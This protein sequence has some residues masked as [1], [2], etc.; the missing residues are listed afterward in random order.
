MRPIS[1]RAFVAGAGA[2]AALAASRIEAMDALFEAPIYPPMD[3]SYFDTPVSPAPADIRLGYASI[4]WGG[5]DLE[6]IADIASLGYPGVQLRSNIVP[7]F[8]ARPAALTDELAKRHLTFVALSSGA[9]S[10]D[11]A[12]E[13]E[14]LTLHAG[15]AKFLKASGGLYLQCTDERP[16]RALVPAD[17]QRLGRLLTEIGKRTADAG[18]A[19]GYHNH[20]GTIGERPDAVDWILDAA[21]PKY[22]K[23]ELDIAHYQQG[24]GDPVKAIRKYADRLL[25]LHIKDVQ[26]MP[27]ASGGPGSYRFVELGRGKVDVKGVFAAMREIKF[28][29]WAVVEL[30]AVPD[31]AR[32]PKEAALMNKKYL[33]D[34]GFTFGAPQATTKDLR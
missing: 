25:F 20:M 28:R 22:V 3:L 29:G 14:Q 31:K 33:E 27:G 18:V 26:D 1:R 11:P 32:T 17:Y 16:K 6:A 13:A 30:D 24:G 7:Q 9:V 21:D 5:K 19:L 34:C 8:E 23:L 12:V 15:H 4:T 2:A 10:I